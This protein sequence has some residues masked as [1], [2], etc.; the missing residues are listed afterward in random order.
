MPII[1]AFAE[2][3]VSH[4][5]QSEKSQPKSKPQAIVNVASALAKL[6]KSSST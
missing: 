6:E 4:I 1:Q 3:G 2:R 5:A